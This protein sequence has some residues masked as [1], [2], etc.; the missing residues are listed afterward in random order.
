[1]ENF[2]KI[3]ELA[4]AHEISTDMDLNVA[5]EL[6]DSIDEKMKERVMTKTQKTKKSHNISK[7]L[8]ITTPFIF[9]SALA[10]LLLPDKTEPTVESEPRA[11]WV[12][13]EQISEYELGM[14]TVEYFEDM[15]P[16]VYDE[17]IQSRVDGIKD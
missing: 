15:M 3:I 5:A 12:I 14:N 9:A 10:L 8:L 13:T 2:Q 7:K 4:T 1:M 16:R 17:E 6:L 11:E